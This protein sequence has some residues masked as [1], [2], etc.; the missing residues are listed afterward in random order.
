MRILNEIRGPFEG[1]A[2]LTECRQILLFDFVQT[3]G[4]THKQPDGGAGW[5]RVETIGVERSLHVRRVTR[6]SLA[7]DRPF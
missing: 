3:L 4:V 1:W 7:L 5:K 6:F 2:G